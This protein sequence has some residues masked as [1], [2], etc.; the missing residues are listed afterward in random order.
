MM[1]HVAV[2]TVDQMIVPMHTYK[3]TVVMPDG[4]REAE[5]TL[6]QF[7]PNLKDF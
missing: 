1:M 3:N 2:F 7:Y 6:A 4:K 5:D